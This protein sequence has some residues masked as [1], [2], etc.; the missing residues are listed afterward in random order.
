MH[1]WLRVFTGALFLALFC[2]LAAPA[3]ALS[4]KKMEELLEQT[5][6]YCLDAQKKA[7]GLPRDLRSKIYDELIIRIERDYARCATTATAE[8][9]SDWADLYV[10]LADNTEDDVAFVLLEKAV[11]IYEKAAGR[12]PKE[13]HVW[14]GLAEVH[15]VRA[16]KLYKAGHE[17][18]ARIQADAGFAVFAKGEKFCPNNNFLNY[19]WGSNLVLRA[20]DVPNPERRALREE[21]IAKF[22]KAAEIQPDD[23]YSLRMAGTAWLRIAADLPDD[24][25]EYTSLLRK[26]ESWYLRAFEVDPGGTCSHLSE[27]RALLQNETGLRETLTQC[28]KNGNLPDDL[29][30]NKDFDFVRKKLWFKQLLGDESKSL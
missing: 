6:E 9:L 10:E 15:H 1:K 18:E 23:Q 28:A 26:A 27:A 16:E 20:Y 12:N 11:P 8:M 14:T 24:N 4:E 25:Q 13:S 29:K 30:T 3:F 21:G 17:E 19:M 22:T 7:E 2:G 5:S